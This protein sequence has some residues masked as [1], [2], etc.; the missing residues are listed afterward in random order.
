MQM[1]E[2]NRS[3]ELV[4]MKETAKVLESV[5]EI[6]TVLTMR[7]VLAARFTERAQKMFTCSTM[8]KKTAKEHRKRM[9]TM[10]LLFSVNRKLL[11]TFLILL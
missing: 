8:S 1:E 7:P 11:S 4:M 6:L 5:R 9:E 2:L 3:Y 10:K